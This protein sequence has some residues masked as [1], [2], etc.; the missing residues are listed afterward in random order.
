M[1]EALNAIIDLGF[2]EMGLNRI[3]AVIMPE[4]SASIKLLEKLGFHNEGI[5]K[6]YENWGSKGLT[7]LCMLALLRKAWEVIK[8]GV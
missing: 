3:E 6:E 5:L 7:D 2:M 4:N 1:T 8:S